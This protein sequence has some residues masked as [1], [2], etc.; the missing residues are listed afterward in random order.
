[1][2]PSFRTRERASSSGYAVTR[3]EGPIPRAREAGTIYGSTEKEAGMAFAR[4]HS[5]QAPA[6]HTWV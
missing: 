1:M 4:Q 3:I 6:T 5:P 2:T